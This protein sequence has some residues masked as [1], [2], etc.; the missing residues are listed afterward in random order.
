MI[1][2]KKEEGKG[3]IIKRRLP[4]S[5]IFET[6]DKI[7]MDFEKE[8]YFRELQM[9]EQ[10]KDRSHRESFSLLD[11]PEDNPL[12]KIIEEKRIRFLKYWDKDRIPIGGGSKSEKRI[13]R[14]F[15]NLRIAEWCDVLR[16]SDDGERNI[17]WDFSSHDS[18][19][20]QYFPEMMDVPTTKGSVLECLRDR[21]RFF[22][23]YENKIFKDGLHR[24]KK[25]KSSFL[26]VFKEMIRLGSGSQPVV[27][28]PSKVAQY[29]VIESYYD[30]IKRS[31][32]I[33]NDNFVVLDPCT[34]WAGR[35]LGLLCAFHKLRNDYRGK[36][37]RELYITYL[38]TD[39]NTD[40]HDRFI[41]I[42]KDWFKDIEPQGYG[43]FFKFYKNTI[44][45]ETPDFLNYCKKILSDLNLKGVNVAVTSPPYFNRE[46]YSTDENQSFK[47]YPVYK[48]WVDN[49][50]TGM[51][52]NVHELL[53]PHGRFYLNIANTKEQGDTNHMQDDSIRLLKEVGMRE[54]IIYKM[55]L[56]GTCKSVNA[57]IIN[58][59]CKKYEPVFVY[60]NAIN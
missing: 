13:T 29:I 3:K 19:L 54:V 58:G 51:I 36:Y 41:N 33:E 37:G 9:Y 44:G 38:T 34:G 49:F 15:K 32:H 11:L 48:Q 25:E 35:L 22:E 10:L 1:I 31:N 52:K 23:S 50:L 8:D 18:G 43:V 21:T 30:T 27:N 46:Q 17:L 26:S 14:D 12:V 56:S 53:I 2:N 60:E 40:V 16:M 5:V 7:M 47:K 6:D 28:F 45:C 4:I 55:T 57:V 59:I 42:V 39:P 20:N 24:F